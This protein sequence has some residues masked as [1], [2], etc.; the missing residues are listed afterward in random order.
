MQNAQDLAQRLNRDDLRLSKSH[1]RI[2]ECIISHYDKV[3]FMTASKLGKYVGVSES[4]V[5]RLAGVLGYK[6]Y[7]QLQKAIQ[8]MIRHRLTASQRFEMTSDMD[9][10][11][12]LT[13][14]LKA[15]MANIRSTMDELDLGAFERAI[16]M[17]L[18]ARR[19]YVLGLRASA[20]LAMFLAHYLNFTSTRVTA[21]TSGVSDIFEQMFRIGPGDLLIGISFPR[22][23][24]RTVEAMHFARGRNASL[25]AITDGPLS[26]LHACADLCLSARSDMASFVDSMA[27]P[28]S[29]I[30]ALIVAVGQRRRSEVGS[31]FQEMEE[32]WNQYDVY[33]KKGET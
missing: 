8:E 29:L 22:Y 33:L 1:K 14:V 15:D 7:P 2:V 24:R 5:V 17:V 25:I 20:P 9:H 16:D 12:V 26:P 28:M 6:G 21:V 4:T 32:V 18:Q 30:N 27:A 31:F 11:Q 19:I 10:T 13:R 23:T 3:A